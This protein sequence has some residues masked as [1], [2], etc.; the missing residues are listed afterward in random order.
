[1][2]DR[3]IIRGYLRYDLYANGQLIEENL[4]VGQS[5][6]VAIKHSNNETNFYGKEKINYHLLTE[7]IVVIGDTTYEISETTHGR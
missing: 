3:R 2:K 6:K 1:M 5:V 4:T 7:G